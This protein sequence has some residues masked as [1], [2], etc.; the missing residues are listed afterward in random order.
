LFSLLFS[1]CMTG[2]KMYALLQRFNFYCHAISTVFFL[3]LKELN[4]D[5]IKSFIG[6]CMEPG[7]ICYLMHCCSRGTIQVSLCW[8]YVYLYRI[9][10]GMF[11]TI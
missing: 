6:A 10:C 11:D 2:D 4:H 9:I 3:Q 5:N 7:N 1:Y 8:R